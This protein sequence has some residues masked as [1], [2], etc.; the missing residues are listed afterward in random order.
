MSGF[1]LNN[2]NGYSP[3]LL[4]VVILTLVFLIVLGAGGP[5]HLRMGMV[6]L[7][8]GLTMILFPP[9]VRLRKVVIW[10][11]TVFLVL[12]CFSFLP[13]SVTG[14]PDWRAGLNDLGVKTGGLNAI[15]SRMAL[16]Y[17]LAFLGLILGGFWILSLRFSIASTRILALLFV[18]GVTGYAI[19]SKI[20]ETQLL[21]DR[22]NQVFGFFPNRN[23]SG[24]LLA[25]GFLCGLGLTFQAVRNKQIGRGVFGL[26]LNGIM[27]WAI[28]SWNASRAAVVICL[29]GFIFWFCLLG[30]RYFGRQEIRAFG[31]MAFLICGVYALSEFQ[32]KERLKET[33]EKLTSLDEETESPQEGGVVNETSLNDL[34]FRVPVAR[35][36]FRL[37]RDFPLTG[38]GAGQFQWV[39]P[40]Y[41]EQTIVAN[42][43]VAIHPESS[44]LWLAAEWGMPA[45]LCLLAL[46]GWSYY[47]GL[48]NIKRRGNRDRAL[49]LGCLVASAMIPIHAVFDV[50]A[51]RPSLLITSLFLFV[52]SQNYVPDEIGL[53]KKS[54]RL[55]GIAAGL[56]LVVAGVFLFGNAWFGW[57]KPLV[58]Q[59]EDQLKRGAELYEKIKEVEKTSFSPR[60]ALLLREE[61]DELTEKAIANSPLQGRLYRL[62][63]LGQLPLTHRAEEAA[64]SFLID[65][66]LT[67]YSVSIPM[68]HASVS[69]P[70]N[71][72][73]VSQGWTEAL[74]RSKKVDE[75]GGDNSKK[76]A[77]TINKIRSS[78]RRIPRY[79]K[80]ADELLGESEK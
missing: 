64:E 19:L 32:V 28:L 34:D 1:K 31:L 55:P 71:E 39:F 78:A 40:Q 42:N 14:A 50:P 43:S 10:G 24:S 66:A 68:I 67:P 59:S 57:E 53:V 12:G 4:G 6:A 72:N 60:K 13:I 52:I 58:V 7:P 36:T 30:I 41:R 35:D 22:G 73:I 76:E 63:G 5:W 80:L 47:R 15:Q 69:L 23:H 17:H 75:I 33:T 25:I 49:R 54:A 2:R 18:V 51:H 29:L 9:V 38:V 46:V 77:V 26:I 8:L 11:G 65:Q 62:R 56:F 61:L 79:Q 74:V 70:Y 3:T 44:W 37:I 27:A 20:F 48:K 21:N 45:A 16:E